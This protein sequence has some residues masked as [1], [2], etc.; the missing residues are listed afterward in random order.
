[1]SHPQDE[2]E[3]MRRALEESGR[4]RVLDRYERPAGYARAEPGT[5]VRLGLYVDVET[6]GL[7]AATDVIIEL[8]LVAFEF[9]RDGAIYRLLEEVSALEDP[10][11][12]IP[13]MIQELTGITDE[14]VRG[15]HLPDE[16][17][18]RLVEHAHLVIAH[19]AG[20]DRPF[21]ERRLPA[22]AQKAWACSASD[23]PWREEGFEGR[24]LEYLALKNGFFYDGHRATNDCL[25]GVHLLSR[26]LPRSGRTALAGLLASARASQARLWAVDSPYESKDLLKARGY[27]WRGH[28]WY[29]D[30][31][32]E[33]LAAEA[34]W[35]RA[36]V[37]Q[38]DLRLPY[39]AITAFMRYSARI[40]A[41]PPAGAP[42]C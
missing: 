12:P 9:D 33:R 34:E 29:I 11:R 17:L 19:N 16:A 14:M 15:Q 7:D 28:G 27:H 32:Q 30:L 31:P 10:G 18:T 23:V 6:T 35:L 8:G 42:C 20:F 2:L 25:A 41:A 4:Y 21:L 1:M 39:H 3:A 36:S 40:P 38:R 37:Y 13:P 5:D 26:R 22:F 24:K